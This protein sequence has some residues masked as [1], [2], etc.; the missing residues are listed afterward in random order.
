MNASTIATNVVKIGVIGYALY[1]GYQ[2]L[3]AYSQAGTVLEKEAPEPVRNLRQPPIGAT[4]GGSKPPE[5]RKRGKGRRRR[6]GKP[7]TRGGNAKRETSQSNGQDGGHDC[8]GDTDILGQAVEDKTLGERVHYTP[9]EVV[10]WLVDELKQKPVFTL[11]PEITEKAIRVITT[12]S[13][14]FDSRVWAR[15]TRRG[16]VVKELNEC[17]PVIDAMLKMVEKMTLQPGQ[18]L[19]IVDLCSGFGFLGMFLAEMLPPD[20]VQKIVLVDRL[21]PMREQKK[22]LPHQIC[23]DHI[24]TPGWQVLLETRK[25]DIRKPHQMRQ[26]DHHVMPPAAGPAVLLCVHLCGTL[27]LRA[28]QL[29]NSSPQ[30]QA[31]LLKPCCLPGRNFLKPPMATWTIGAHSFTAHDVY[32]PPK[33]KVV[34]G[35]E[36]KHLG[37]KKCFCVWVDHLFRGVDVPDS[38]KQLK[39][40]IIQQD[41]FQN[42]YIHAMR[43]PQGERGAAPASPLPTGSL[44]EGEAAMNTEARSITT[45]TNQKASPLPKS[46]QASPF[47]LREAGSPLMEGSPLVTCTIAGGQEPTVATSNSDLSTAGVGATRPFGLAARETA[48]TG[49]R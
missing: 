37:Q 36:A 5:Q 26:F 2:V 39:Q 17:A 25:A 33:G 48:F 23:W 1:K 8:G 13:T 21:W 20:K 3:S 10:T 44:E 6:K 46:P 34:I 18:K 35:G 49:L 11:Y 43:T 19:T 28:V 42:L 4:P 32:F 24:H 31:M 47:M 9:A 7:E 14:R 29:F 27:S 22:A 30:V 38:C 15:F 40:I 12:W 16:R 41:H 45:P